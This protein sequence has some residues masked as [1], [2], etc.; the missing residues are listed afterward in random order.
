MPF[1][2]YEM[3]FN[4]EQNLW[5]SEKVEASLK[6]EASA[7]DQTFPGFHI[8]MERLGLVEVVINE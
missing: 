8:L 5:D 1:P 7:M 3:D 2:S 6:V 4:L